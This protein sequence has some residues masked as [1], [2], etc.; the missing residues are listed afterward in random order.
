MKRAD[1]R[2]HNAAR[3]CN[4]AHLI[5]FLCF[6]FFQAEDGI[7]DWS[8]TGVQTCALPISIWR[9][10]R[11]SGSVPA[12]RPPRRAG[13]A[14]PESAPDRAR[15]DGDAPSQ[16][17]LSRTPASVRSE[18]RRV[19]KECRTQGWREPKRRKEDRITQAG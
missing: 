2:Q 10:L 16:G 13:A 4:L 18:E 8:V 12:S 5:C 7:R 3:G 15:A 14:Q 6:F 9:A 17:R 1:A 19:G 11:L